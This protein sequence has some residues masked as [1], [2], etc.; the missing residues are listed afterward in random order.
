[1]SPVSFTHKNLPNWYQ[2][3]NLIHVSS[4]FTTNGKPPGLPFFW[5]KTK[6]D[7]MARPL[8]FPVMRGV[9]LTIEDAQKLEAMCAAKQLHPSDLLR[10]LIQT[11][12]PIEGP[13]PGQF[14][15]REYRETECML[16]SA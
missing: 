4:T 6:E 16:Q 12:P 8:R 9:R 3:S 7:T 11:A 13:A 10:W 14:E 1:M 2:F 15:A 5:S